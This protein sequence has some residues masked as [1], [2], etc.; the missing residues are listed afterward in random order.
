[1]RRIAGLL[2]APEVSIEL[3]MLDAPAAKILAH[4]EA[5]APGRT[6]GAGVPNPGE[7]A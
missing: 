6:S 4:I 2:N 1:M 3:P 7:E 5:V